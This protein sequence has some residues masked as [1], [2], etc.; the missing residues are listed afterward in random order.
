MGRARVGGIVEV[1]AIRCVGGVIAGRRRDPGGD[2][3]CLVEPVW[4]FEGLGFRVWG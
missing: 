1:G 3:A 2:V 4:L